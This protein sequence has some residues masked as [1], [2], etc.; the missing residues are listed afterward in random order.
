MA[1]ELALSQHPEADALLSRASG[2]LLS[3]ASAS[4]C[5]DRASSGAIRPSGLSLIHI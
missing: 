4:G 3:R 1:P 2:S 5:C